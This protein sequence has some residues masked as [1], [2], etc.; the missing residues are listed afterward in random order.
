[1][2]IVKKEKMKNN[3]NNEKREQIKKL[4]WLLKNRPNQPKI[5]DDN[6]YKNNYEKIDWSK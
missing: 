1:M 6:N 3:Y 5:Y 4:D 2:L